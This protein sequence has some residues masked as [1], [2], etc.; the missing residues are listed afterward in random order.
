MHTVKNSSLHP[1][2]LAAL[3]LAACHVTRPPLHEAMEPGWCHDDADND[4]DGAFDCDDPDCMGTDLCSEQAD[5]D[6]DTDA[7]TDTDTDT[8]ADADADTDTDADAD[9]DADTDTGEPPR[10]V[11]IVAAWHEVF[12]H[13]DH[14]DYFAELSGQADLVTLD[15]CQNYAGD[16]EELH[17]M[18]RTASDPHGAWENW[19]LTLLVVD[20]PDG[21]ISGETTT[22]SCCHMNW[23]SMTWMVTAYLDDEVGDCAVWGADVT[24]YADHGCRQF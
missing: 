6:T 7:D 1:V 8:D 15:F 13:E 11:E 4:G 21:F 18:L 16:Y 9:T 14:W 17:P 23:D 22:M 5:T 12:E 2:S 24:V 3:L 19:E 20:S 10:T